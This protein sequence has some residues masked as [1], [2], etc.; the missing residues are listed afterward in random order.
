MNEIM[1]FLVYAK[2]ISLD[3]DNMVNKKRLYGEE[4]EL[5][6]IKKKWS[7]FCVLIQEAEN[8]KIDKDIIVRSLSQDI[9]CQ[10]IKLA[11]VCILTN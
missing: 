6:Q 9:V 2:G 7:D 3:L 8:K 10:F 11:P 1:W 4:L 5:D